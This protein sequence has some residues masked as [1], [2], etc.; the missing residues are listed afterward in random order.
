MHCSNCGQTLTQNLN[1][2]QHCGSRNKSRP[3]TV[4]NSPTNLFICAGGAIGVIGLIGFYPILRELLH[5]GVGNET[6]VIILI[7]YLTAVFLMFSVLVGL[8]WKR[9]GVAQTAGEPRGD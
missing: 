3:V 7:S 8:A 9:S 4:S 1:Y 2:C 5:S 6:I